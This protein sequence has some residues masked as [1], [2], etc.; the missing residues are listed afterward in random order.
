MATTPAIDLKKLP[1]LPP[2]YEIF[3]FKP[4]EPAYFKIVDYQIGTMEIV[5]RYP[6]APERKKIV[7][8]RIFV[9]PET[10]KYFPYYWD[11]T[12]S[13]LVYFLADLLARGI[14]KGMWLKIHRDVPG[15]SAHFEVA[16]VSMPG[17]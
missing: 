8:I 15:P 1:P 16:W 10:K 14:P 13:R 11:I 17:E 5:P 7:A 12:P 6:G 2:P 4:C 9:D 3:E